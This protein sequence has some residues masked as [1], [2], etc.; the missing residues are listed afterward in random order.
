MVVALTPNPPYKRS[1]RWIRAEPVA[2][3]VAEKP[4]LLTEKR[5]EGL[6][7]RLRAYTQYHG[8]FE[9]K[10]SP[11]Y[12]ATKYPTENCGLKLR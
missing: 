6:D 5:G 12:F 9:M 2:V 1:I 3:A 10:S 11:Q 4:T 8:V 7:G